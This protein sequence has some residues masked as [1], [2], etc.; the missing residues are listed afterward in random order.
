MR[1]NSKPDIENVLPM[2]VGFWFNA[3]FKHL[4]ISPLVEYE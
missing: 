2:I 4:A 3:A 1:P